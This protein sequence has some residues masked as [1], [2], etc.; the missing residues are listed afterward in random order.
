MTDS[1][2]H[3]APQETTAT[4]AAAA[5][6]ATEA[7]AAKPVARGPL[8]RSIGSQRSGSKPVRAK[9]QRE[10]SGESRD[11]RPVKTTPVPNTREKLAPEDELELAAAMGE[12]SLD[13]MLDPTASAI[14]AE[15]EPDTKIQ[16]TI[17]SIHGD[18]VF[19]DLGG[20]NQG[21][22]SARQL[23]KDPEVG[24]TLQVIVQ[25]YNAEDELYQVSPSLHTAT[26]V[27]DW[28]QVSEGMVV[29]A[30]VTGHNKGGLECQVNQLRGFIPASQI[31][32]YRVENLEQY[33]GQHLT[34][35]VHE[36]NVERRN[37]VLSARAIIER[38]REEAKSQAL[39]ELQEG[40]VREGTVRSVQDFGAFVDIG[41]VDG[42]VHVSQLSWQRVNNPADV[43]SVGQRVKVLIKK[44]DTA[45]GKIGLSM[46]DLLDNPWHTLAERKPV[47]SVI[48]GKVTRLMD[49]GAFVEVEPGVEGL[50]HVSE[51]SVGRVFRVRDVV[52][53]GQEVEAKV[54]SID[55]EAQRMSLSIKAAAMLGAPLE[56]EKPGEEAPPPTPLTPAQIAAQ[57]NLKGGIA[58]QSGGEKFGLKW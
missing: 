1:A 37:L 33:V 10:F 48:R 22:V 51:L 34:C 29:E 58:K 53:V 3:P 16:G 13:E 31:A 39:S 41:G 19:V 18:D 28:S 46:R 50:V 30:R 57:K 45:S 24:D 42:L 7:Q 27:E 55:P 21:V 43:V 5:P 38:Q 2:S 17:L 15:I 26:V 12:Q 36:A 23:V 11:P 47:T 14:A 25:R 40:Q 9:P 8:S 32:P 52:E 56:D 6:A 54:L 44:I 49:F 4:P 20:R 35:V